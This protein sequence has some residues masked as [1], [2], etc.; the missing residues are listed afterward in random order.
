MRYFNLFLCF[1][2][3]SLSINSIVFAQSQLCNANF[4]DGA[5]AADVQGLVSQGADANE[6][7]NQLGQL[8][9]LHIALG[10]DTQVSSGVVQALITAGGDVFAQAAGLG[11]VVELS[12]ERFEEAVS[13]FQAQQITFAEF[14]DRQAVYNAINAAF[15]ARSA[16]YQ[17]LCDPTWWRTASGQTVITLLTSNPGIDPNRSCNPGN[18]RPLH[19][20][21]RPIE[22][23][24]QDTSS[25]ILTFIANTNPDLQ[26]GNS[27]NETPASLL[28]I[29]YDRLRT[30]VFRDLDE[31]CQNVTQASV[32]RYNRLNNQ[33]NP[34]I[35]LYAGIRERM[36]ESSTAAAQRLAG[37]FFGNPQG[38]QSIQQVCA[39]RESIR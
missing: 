17:N 31:M 29:R 3:F 9:P 39:Y 38:I 1:F 6:I 34:E 8:R 24:T 32:D 14:N 16:A 19:I 11:T 5:T 21:L 20:A 36:G 7:C 10:P 28:E 13:A 15:E 23:V 30:R 18:D 27:S 26:S 25:A 35:G 12:E 4:L 2:V 33:Y 37:D 22:P